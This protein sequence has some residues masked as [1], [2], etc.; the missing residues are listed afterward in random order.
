M[1]EITGS[2]DKIARI[3]KV[4]D[5]IAFQTNILALNAAVE[6]A[7]AGEAGAGFA[8]VADEVRSLAQRCAVAARD[9]TT[10]IEESVLNSRTGQSKVT[11]IVDAIRTIAEDSKRVRELVDEVNLG[12]REQARG[13]E[14]IGKAMTQMEHVTQ[15]TAAIAEESASAAEELNAQ[16]QALM[17][18]VDRLS[19][20]AGE[21]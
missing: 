11:E 8:V 4:I 1:D 16:S 15:S 18:V 6:A 13:I 21:R 7:R 12:G 9:T 19:A 10:L 2:S 3:I 5:D 17:K 20:M 14:H